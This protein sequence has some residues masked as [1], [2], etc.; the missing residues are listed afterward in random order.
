MVLTVGNMLL[1]LWGG[2]PV[3]LPRPR[4]WAFGLRVDGL[5]FRVVNLIEHKSN[6][7]HRNSYA[8]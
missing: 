4:A 3:A 2:A 1:K 5:E 8:K 7:H 6:I